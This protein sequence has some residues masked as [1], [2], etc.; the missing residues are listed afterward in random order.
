[1]LL[2]RV[3]YAVFQAQHSL[4]TSEKA[5][6]IKA[7]KQVGRQ[8]HDSA[9]HT[10]L[11]DSCTQKNAQNFLWK[12]GLLKTNKSFSGVF[13]WVSSTSYSWECL[14]FSK[15]TCQKHETEEYIFR[16]AM[17][18]YVFSFSGDIV[19]GWLP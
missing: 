13:S 11:M 2:E 9:F 8:M 6:S 5:E 3:L 17:G 7:L 18:V 12:R 19:L 15:S 16:S 4:D 14:T 10:H 1:M